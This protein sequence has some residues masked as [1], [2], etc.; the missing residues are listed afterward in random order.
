MALRV[1]NVELL[2]Q[3]TLKVDIVNEKGTVLLADV[4]AKKI[5][6]GA[7]EAEFNPPSPKFKVIIKGKTTKG[8]S[9]QRLSNRFSEAQKV[10]MV[11]MSGGEEFTASVAGRQS[12]VRVYVYNGGAAE[13]LT[14]QASANYGSASAITSYKVV[15][16]AS[17]TTVDF[18]YTLS[19][20]AS[21]HVGK[22]DTISVKATGTASS[23]I[24]TPVDL[25]IVN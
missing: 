21:S 15:Q 20:S 8:N 19:G 5:G 6:G 23:Q 10:V 11:A 9:F 3:S 13:R 22:T 14:F 12:K 16:K 2:D 17:N 4:A 24:Q 7:F 1:S 18:T 25:L